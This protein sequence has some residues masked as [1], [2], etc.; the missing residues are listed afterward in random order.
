M[1]PID[2]HSISSLTDRNVGL[3]WNNRPAIVHKDSFILE[4]T[5][6]RADRSNAIDDI[7]DVTAE[8]TKCRADI[9]NVSAEHT[10]FTSYT[11]IV[12]RDIVNVSAEHT[13][14]MGYTR[15]AIVPQPSVVATIPKSSFSIQ[16][17]QFSIHSS[18]L[19]SS[20]VIWQSRKICSTRPLP[21][22]SPA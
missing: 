2:R 19:N 12:S 10:E 11:R 6:C 5:E 7:V 8:Y 17:S 3:R 4:Y 1:Q 18:S 20:L 16:N 9:V 22:V 13:E 14:F 21:I 15:I